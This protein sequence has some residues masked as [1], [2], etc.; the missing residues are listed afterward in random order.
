MLKAQQPPLV[1]V[2]AAGGT[3]AS[4]AVTSDAGSWHIK[5][6]WEPVQAGRDDLPVLVPPSPAVSL[7]RNS[8]K[9]LSSCQ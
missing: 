8:S 4:P 3:A 5:V 7:G 9:R 2:P 6:D 1:S